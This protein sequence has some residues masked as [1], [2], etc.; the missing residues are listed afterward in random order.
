MADD[1]TFQQ[2]LTERPDDLDLRMVYADWLEET[3]DLARASFLRDQQ[4]LATSDPDAKD[5]V[6]RGKDLRALGESLPADWVR[7][8][9]FPRLAG[10]V[11]SGADS[12]NQS[13]VLR[14]LPTGKLSYSQGA[15]TWE[16]GTWS[17]V[18]NVLVAETNGHYADYEGVVAGTTLRGASRNIARFSWTWRVERTVDPDVVEPQGD[19]ITTVYDGHGAARRRRRRRRASAKPARTK[20]ARAKPSPAKSSP[21]KPSPAKSPPAK[22]SSAKPARA[23]SS[24][25]KPARAKAAPVKP[26]VAKSPRA[27]AAPASSART[28]PARPKP[29]RTKSAARAK[30][31]NRKSGSK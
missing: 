19:V 21:A 16:N 10:T 13:L 3:G 2:L 17:Q 27:S 24:S 29:A 15:T 28:K 5:L 1:A 26:G 4:A 25:A 9:S 22:S 30:S 23:K 18:G 12:T 7:L 20:A 11:W 14:F 6:A 8:V 31:V